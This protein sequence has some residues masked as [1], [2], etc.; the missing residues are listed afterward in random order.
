MS[1]DAALAAR[2]A[3]REHLRRQ[4][5]GRVIDEL[6][7]VEGPIEERVPGFRVFRVRPNRPG[8]WW[9]YVTSGCWAATQQDGHGTEFFLAAPRDEWVNLESVSMNA[10]Y[11]CGPDHQRLDVGHTVPIGRP[12]LDDSRCDHYL[13]SLPYPYG[14][15]FE[16]CAWDETAHAQI[17]W[18][19][20]ITKAEKDYRREQGLE[21]LENLF[22]ERAI[23]PVDP[24]R[25]SV[26]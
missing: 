21:E 15:D 11:H 3:M 25:P 12:W 13:I 18:L 5:P 20:P 14:P 17:L 10:Y 9:V 19:L 7:G 1:V 26:V 8:G 6:P 23:N 2:A 4:F 22:D 16:V 24:Q